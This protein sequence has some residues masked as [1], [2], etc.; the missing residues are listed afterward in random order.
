MV[1]L[2]EQKAVGL[3]HGEDILSCGRRASLWVTSPDVEAG[4]VGVDMTMVSVNSWVDVSVV[5]RR[6]RHGNG[7]VNRSEVQVHHPNAAEWGN[8]VRERDGVGET[9]EEEHGRWWWRC[10]DRDVWMER[11]GSL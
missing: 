3:R 10:V 11:A 4:E 2:G 6:I 9:G 1:R 5:S 7:S 8:R